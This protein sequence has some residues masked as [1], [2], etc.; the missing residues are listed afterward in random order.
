[1][2]ETIAEVVIATLKM[3][4]VQRVY[5]APGDSLKSPGRRLGRRSDTWNSKLWPFSAWAR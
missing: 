4:G 5:G 2:A 3:S 1:M